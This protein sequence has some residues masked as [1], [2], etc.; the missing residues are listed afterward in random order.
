MQEK[1]KV[2]DYALFVLNKPV[3]VCRARRGRIFSII[4]LPLRNIRERPWKPIEPSVDFLSH[5]SLFGYGTSHKGGPDGQLRRL[6]NITVWE[7][8]SGGP[9]ICETEFG[10][11]IF[12]IVSHSEPLV[13]SEPSTCFGETSAFLYDVMSDV[14]KM[15]PQ[16]QNSLEEMG[17][18]NEFIEDYEKC[19]F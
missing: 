2:L 11:R 13:E 16:I 6:K 4:K 18:I 10:E 8:D 14:R 9:F 15:L 3:P 1:G 17:K 19:D 12:G 5:C 7:G